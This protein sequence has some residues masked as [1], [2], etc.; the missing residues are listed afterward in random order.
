MDFFITITVISSQEVESNTIMQV[1]YGE[2]KNKIWL[3]P[4]FVT[5]FL[6]LVFKNSILYLHKLEEKNAPG[7][8]LI[9]DSIILMAL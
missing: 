4:S 5:Y 8:Q 9:A 7:L 3:W 1:G 2:I 6:V